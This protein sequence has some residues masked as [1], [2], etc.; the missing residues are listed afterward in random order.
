M[1]ELEEISED[2]GV[3]ISIATNVPSTRKQ[4]SRRPSDE[5]ERADFD[6]DTPTK[7]KTL[8]CILKATNK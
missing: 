1:C 8:C 4:Q 7:A 6:N 3:T 2:T 5:E